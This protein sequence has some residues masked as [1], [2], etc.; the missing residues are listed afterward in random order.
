MSNAL[1]LIQVD[2]DDGGSVLIN[3]NTIDTITLDCPDGSGIFTR[4]VSIKT[5]QSSLDV[6]IPIDDLKG[7]L[8]QA[9]VV[10]L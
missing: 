10:I 8:Q 7:R 1:Y 4:I 9:G 2:T 3:P 6:D 5:G